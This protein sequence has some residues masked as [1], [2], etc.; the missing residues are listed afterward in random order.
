MISMHT[1][2]VWTDIKKDHRL[3]EGLAFASKS[4]SEQTGKV[5]VEK[6]DTRPASTQVNS[7]EFSVQINNLKPLILGAF[8]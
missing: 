1:L 6:V 3:A 7:L 4:N 5:D 2:Q 8:H